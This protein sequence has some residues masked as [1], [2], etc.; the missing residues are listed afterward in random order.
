MAG[1]NPGRNSPPEP[2]PE[3]EALR[4]KNQ[5]EQ[6]Y[7]AGNLKSALKYAKRAHRL[8]SSLEALPEMLT[9][10]KILR[11]AT[12]PFTSTPPERGGGDGA[13]SIPPAP[14]DYYKILQIERFAHINTIKKQYKK[15]ALTLHPDKNPFIASEE[16]FK[17][18]G[19][20]FRVLSDRIRRKEYD[21]SLR[22]AMQNEAEA[23][24]GAAGGGVEEVET[25]WTACSTCRLLHK[26]E[27]K[28]LG[29]NLVCPSCKKSFKAVE[30]EVEE[31]EE[32]NASTV[33]RGE[34]GENVGLRTSERIKARR[35]GKMSSVGGVLE[36]SGGKHKGLREKLMVKDLENVGRKRGLE[37]GGDDGVIEE[38]R[39][40]SEKKE[41]RTGGV[42]MEERATTRA[43]TKR[44]KVDEEETM[45]LAEMQMLAKKKVSQQKMKLKAKEKEVEEREKEKDKNMGNEELKE[46]EN[47]METQNEKSKEKEIEMENEKEE[48]EIEKDT[49][50]KQQK[51][52]EKESNMGLERVNERE[53]RDRKMGV[54]SNE[55]SMEV[56]GRRASRSSRDLVIEKRKR[57]RQNNREIVAVEASDFY[58]FDEDRVERSFKKGQVWAIYDSEDGMPRRYALIDEVVSLNPF[59]VRLSWLE[60]QNNGDEQL[61][62][63]EKIGFHISCG[64]FKVSEKASV[65]SPKMFSH[66]PDC[67]RAAKEVYRIYPKKGS[68]WA[69]YDENALDSGRKQMKNKGCYDIVVFLTSYSEIHGLSM[70]YLEKV[71]GYKT[72][73]KR[74]EFGAHAVRWLVKDEFRLFSHQIPGRKLSG[75]EAPG[76]PRDCWELDPACLPPNLLTIGWVNKD[77]G[78]KL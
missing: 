37:G 2:E 39:S 16:A 46:K 63:W 71:D 24:A 28:Y 5:A 69:L 65:K 58:N 4:L 31:E 9:S 78:T 26:F 76:L 14:P 41:G 57:P 25:F 3:S 12:K 55:K 11:T 33:Q 18:V 59:Q 68:V 75:E 66:L 27:S 10:F 64:R 62:G 44:V 15:L 49:Q 19:E 23:A 67:E 22:I 53:K 8:Q 7:V 1:G 70:A 43:R 34:E 54:S 74:K 20:A 42:E 48:E 6:K 47:E 52:N 17:R 38:L 72:I 32:E 51:L 50:K 73:F 29:H 13:A 35:L 40:R 60:F 21:M 45:T 77:V 36:R 30:V 56:V 61:I